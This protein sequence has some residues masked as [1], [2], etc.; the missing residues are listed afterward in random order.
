MNKQELLEG[1]KEDAVKIGHSQKSCN[2][3]FT[4]TTMND[5]ANYSLDY[6]SLLVGDGHITPEPGRLHTIAG[7]GGVGKTRMA[8]N[9]AYCGA[10]EEP[11]M[12]YTIKNRFNT[13]IIQNENGARRLHSDWE[14][15]Y[16]EVKDHVFFLDLSEGAPFHDPRFREAI[17]DTI[18]LKRIGMII[19]DP[20]TN[21]VG[22]TD[23]K[24]YSA[25]INDIFAALP[26][27]P[28]Q[29]PAV[30]IVAHCKKPSGNGNP[31]RGAELQ[32]DI[33]GSQVLVARSRFVLL[34]ER[35]DP[36]DLND[37]RVLVHCVKASDALSQP[38]GCFRRGRLPLPRF[39]TTTGMNGTS[40][41]KEGP[42]RFTACQKWWN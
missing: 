40:Q 37:D 23:H 29:C 18:I 25:L 28:A 19:I 11:W 3:W 2:E 20:W 41:P 6:S 24:N 27:D 17:H 5:I 10:T 39:L 16:N 1:I 7:Y 4:I 12:G 38:R 33:L 22:D 31:R 13:L 15:K 32:H 9:L 36:T 21:F 30:V 42:S 35:A 8:F 26:N 14:G 34:A